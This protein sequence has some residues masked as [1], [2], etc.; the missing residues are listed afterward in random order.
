M[1]KHSTRIMGFRLSH[2]RLGSAASRETLMNLQ[3][4]K[5]L[6]VIDLEVTPKTS[7]NG[8]SDANSGAL[9]GSL[10][11][12]SSGGHVLDVRSGGARA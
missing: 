9:A 6:K 3:H 11:C 1:S 2:A 12:P 5:N 7:S 8:Q 10:C 4:D